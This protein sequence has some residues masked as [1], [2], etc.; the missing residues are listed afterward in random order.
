MDLEGKVAE[1]QHLLAQECPEH[2][3]LT[4]LNLGYS[5]S[6]RHGGVHDCYFGGSLRSAL[7]LLAN[8][9]LVCYLD[10]DDWL[11]HNHVSLMVQVFQQLPNIAWAYPLSYYADGATGEVLCLDEIESVG[12]NKGFYKANSGGFVRPSGLTI[13]KLKTLP[14]IHCLSQS[15]TK[16][17]DGEDRVFFDKLKTLEYAFLNAGT[18]CYTLDPKDAM[19]SLRMKY[20]QEKL[21]RKV[22]IGEKTGSLR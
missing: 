7:T 5:T 19:H 14:F 16:E 22:S 15:L 1:Y 11:L 9:P 2:I 21:G 13:N 3:Q 4:W 12:V 6:K 8:S 17:G 10:D 18:V 20:I